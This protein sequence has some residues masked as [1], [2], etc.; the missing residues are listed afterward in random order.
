M[1]TKP[2]E[3]EAWFRSSFMPSDQETYSV[4]STVPGTHYHVKH[5]AATPY[6]IKQKTKTKTTES[7]TVSSR[8]QITVILCSTITIT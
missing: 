7:P 2:N 8:G 1:Q 4:Y 5:I 6:R 3:T